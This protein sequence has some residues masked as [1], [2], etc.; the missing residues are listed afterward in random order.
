MKLPFFAW[1]PSS[2]LA[3]F[4][5]ENVFMKVFAQQMEKVRQRHKKV[6]KEYSGVFIRFLDFVTSAIDT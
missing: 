3:L 2:E 1:L 4:A 6:R 5:R